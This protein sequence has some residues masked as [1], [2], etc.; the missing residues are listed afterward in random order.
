M[1]VCVL[2]EVTARLP[3]VTQM[4]LIKILLLH[5]F[6]WKYNIVWESLELKESCNWKLCVEQSKPDMSENLL[7]MYGKI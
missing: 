4:F 7:Q 3:T 2:G 6:Y 5:E 1:S